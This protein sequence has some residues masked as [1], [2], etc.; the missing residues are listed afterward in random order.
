MLGQLVLEDLL[1]AEPQGD[2]LLGALDGVGAV[3][4]IAADV[5]CFPSQV[6][7]AQVLVS[8]RV[9]SSL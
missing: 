6:S 4:D 7:L 8:V 1:L 3:A 5:L 9:S 2:F